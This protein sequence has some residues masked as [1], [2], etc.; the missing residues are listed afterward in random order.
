MRNRQLRLGIALLSFSAALW[1]AD[2][3]L[4]G[5]WKL[6]VAKSSYSSGA[7]PQSTIS[8]YEPY[9]KDGFR[10]TSDTVNAQGKAS[11][12]SYVS[13]YDGKDY[14]ITGDPARDSNS[15]KRID[16]YTHLI[17]NKKNGNVTTTSRRVVSKDGKTL[18]ITTTGTTP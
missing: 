15:A 8:S 13:E 14:P 17:T 1:A 11:H 6:D 16:L 7:P 9:G 10:F 5:T 18:T 12:I 3:P 2:D 4:M